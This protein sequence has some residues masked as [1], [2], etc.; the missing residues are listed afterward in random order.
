VKTGLNL[1]IISIAPTEFIGDC[2]TE[3]NTHGLIYA[4]A[5]YST[6]SPVQLLARR[7]QRRLWIVENEQLPTF[8]KDS[9]QATTKD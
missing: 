8:L 2:K 3:T 7:M 4:S 5:A 6:V 9:H 1:V